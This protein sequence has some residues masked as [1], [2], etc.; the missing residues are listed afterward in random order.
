MFKL[1][2]NEIITDEVQPIILATEENGMETYE[3]FVEERIIG[4]R[5]LWDKMTKGKQ[6]TRMHPNTD[7][8]IMMKLLEYL[9][10]ND[11]CHTSAQSTE[12]EEG[13]ETCLVVD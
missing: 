11:T 9:I 1:V 2:S 12:L 10:V 3:M 4:R 7:K 6:R 5:N 8:S 13:S